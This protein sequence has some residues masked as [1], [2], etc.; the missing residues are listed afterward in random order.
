M[1]ITGAI[2]RMNEKGKD[3]LRIK[4]KSRDEMNRSQGLWRSVV[5]TREEHR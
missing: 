5:G 1:K 3:C 2:C 4:S